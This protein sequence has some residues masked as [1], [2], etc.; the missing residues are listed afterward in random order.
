V[1]EVYVSMEWSAGDRRIAWRYAGAL[2]EKTFDDPPSSAISWYEPPSVIVVEAIRD[3]SRLD[4]AVVFDLDGP[5]RLRLIPPNIWSEPSWR[6]GF[7]TVYVSQGE[8]IAVF[9]TRN[10]DFW[11]KPDLRTGEITDLTEW[12]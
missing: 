9:S 2:V 4:N 5:E 12:R 1:S 6:L 7:H 3:G 11:G 8:M 10:G